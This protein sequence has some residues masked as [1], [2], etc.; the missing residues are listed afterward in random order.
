MTSIGRSDDRDRSLAAAVPEIQ[1]PVPAPQGPAGATQT[2]RVRRRTWL[3]AMVGVLVLPVAVAAAI[4]FT[5]AGSGVPS[6]AAV[7]A[8]RVV[9]AADMESEYGIK[10]NLVGVSAGGGMIDLRFTVTDKDKAIHLLHDAT[11]MP[12]LL[13]EPSG[14]VIR[15]PTGMRHKVTVLD[16]GSYFIL[17]P[18]PGGAIQAGTPVSVVIDSVRLAPLNAQS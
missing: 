13:V 17:Y 3:A 10:V 15:A 16:G 12:E 4:T 11:V 18:N 2:L 6:D 14:K 9:S 8:A 7:A 1:D 5:A